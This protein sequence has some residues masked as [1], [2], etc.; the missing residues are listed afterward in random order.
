[1][2]DAIRDGKKRDR[3][4]FEEFPGLAF[5][6]Q[7]GIAACKQAYGDQ[8]DKEKTPKIIIYWGES[9]TGK[10]R[11]ATSEYPEAYVLSKDNGNG[12]IWWDGYEGQ[13]CVVF[14]EFY[15]WVKY[16]MLLRV[17]DRYPLRVQVKGGSVEFVA[18]TFV[19]TSNKPWEEWYSDD[20]RGKTDALGR[21][22]REWGTVV[23]MGEEA[24]LNR[25]E[26]RMTGSG[27]ETQI[28]FINDRPEGWFD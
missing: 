15:G 12:A 28:G 22:I 17:L 13:D 6:Y 27:G 14:D 21:R 1:M 23:E 11:R 5:K 18:T 4:I 16:D 10:T 20:V 25:L 24:K 7:R 8:R 9:G 2:R 26:A 19:F 3:D